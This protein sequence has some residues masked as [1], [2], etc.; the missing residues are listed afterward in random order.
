MTQL[1]AELE[2]RTQE[3]LAEDVTTELV[4]SVVV[5][6]SKSYVIVMVFYFSHES[7]LLLWANTIMPHTKEHNAS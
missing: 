2:P 4:G 7:S 5:V 1:E 6:L 3:L